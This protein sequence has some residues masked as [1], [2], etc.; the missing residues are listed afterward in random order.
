MTVRM[1][2]LMRGEQNGSA[3]V[4][5]VPAEFD[6]DT[7]EGKVINQET[8]GDFHAFIEGVIE[9][10]DVIASA[11]VFEHA[12]SLRDNDVESM[13]DVQKHDLYMRLLASFSEKPMELVGNMLAGMLVGCVESMVDSPEFDELYA[14]FVASDDGSE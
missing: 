4:K 12:K 9:D 7:K 13:S 14:A 1:V 2:L 8:A 5:F 10:M 3:A 6:L 11:H